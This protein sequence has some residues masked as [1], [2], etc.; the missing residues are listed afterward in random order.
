[1][2]TR[3]DIARFYF[4]LVL[5]SQMMTLAGPVINIGVGRSLDPT[6]DFAAY[7]LAFSVLLFIESPCLS[8]Q[9]VGVTLL[10]G[11]ESFRRVAIV[12][13]A[14]GVLATLTVLAV[15]L[16][17]I[18]DWVFGQLIP[19]TDRVSDLAREVL[20]LQALV[21]VFISIRGVANSL[22]IRSKQ[23]AW[24]ARATVLRLI[25]L[26]AV[27]AIGVFLETGSGAKAGATALV[28]G[29]GLETLAISFSVRSVARE[30][31]A[32]RVSSR[33]SLPYGNL[34]RVA[35]PL[36]VAAFAWTLLRPIINA[37]LGYLPDPERA[38]AGFG[39]IAPLILV[40]CSPL[41]TMHN[42]SLVLPQTP[43][44]FRVVAR[45]A[46]AT[47]AFFTSVIL[48]F[49]FTPLQHWLFDSV[50]N[51]SP[52]LQEDVKIAF[53]WVALEP[54]ILTVRSLAQGLLMK[55][56]RTG[57]LMTFAPGKIAILL[58]VGLPAAQRVDVEHGVLLG[59]LLYILSDTWDAVVFS[60]K[61]RQYAREGRV[62]QANSVPTAPDLRK[63]HERV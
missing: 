62:F 37:L 6:L 63:T 26:S 5:T 56:K 19:T 46:V 50:Y 28:V 38:Q 10:D 23:T 25:G 21:P 22:A 9:Q 54:A 60:W 4:P 1:M 48:I 15:A 30:W 33:G 51:L 55:A 34:I 59:T 44:D 36:L 18:G 27:V 43:N 29:I 12:S 20:A 52:I 35:T 41:W 11:F 14:S 31:Y 32:K 7:W 2:L 42:V 39:V 17:P 47:A 24:I 57:P 40:S 49:A 3:Q 13:I 58:L 61:A 53:R 16:T 45:F 8:V